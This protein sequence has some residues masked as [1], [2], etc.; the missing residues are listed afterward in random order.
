M[1]NGLTG[2]TG[3]WD[4]SCI[5][6]LSAWAT[7]SSSNEMRKEFSTG[8]FFFDFPLI[9]CVTVATVGFGGTGCFSLVLVPGGL[10]PLLSSDC[11]VEAARLLGNLPDVPIRPVED[12][13]EFRPELLFK[14]G[15]PPLPVDIPGE[16]LRPDGRPGVPDLLPERGTKSLSGD[17]RAVRDVLRLRDEGGR[18]E[19]LTG[20]S[21]YNAQMEKR[22]M[23]GKE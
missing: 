17:V 20:G 10:V 5:L 3:G 4:V 19:R 2:D 14:P 21:S 12:P 16:P 9:P 11:K 7:D 18:L 1:L 15:V 23:R 13:G 22:R 8:L 6:S